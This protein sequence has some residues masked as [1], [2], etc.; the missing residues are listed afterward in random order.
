M[1]VTGQC[2]EPHFEK[3]SLLGDIWQRPELE[4]EMLNEVEIDHVLKEAPRTFNPETRGLG[5][6][7]RKV[8][9]IATGI[10]DSPI[11]VGSEAVRNPQL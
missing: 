4:G 6:Y 5:V 11:R 7:G 3:K 9:A 2:T 8:I 1:D 10:A